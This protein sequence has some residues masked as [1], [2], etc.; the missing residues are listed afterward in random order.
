MTKR[1]WAGL[2]AAVIVLAVPGIFFVKAATDRDENVALTRN[3]VAKGPSGGRVWRGTMT[4]RSDDS[5]YRDVAV[6]VRFLDRNGRPVGEVSGRADRLEA[7]KGLDLE[8]PLPALATGM[9]MH[10]LHWRTGDVSADLGPYA[11]WPFGHVQE[12]FPRAACR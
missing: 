5:L 3:E 1:G 12:C 7:G 10:K 11:A 6:T 4:N 2:A 9:Q 8:A